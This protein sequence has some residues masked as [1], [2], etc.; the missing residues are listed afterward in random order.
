MIGALFDSATAERYDL[1]NKVCA[2]AELDK[3]VQALTEVMLA[4]NPIALRRTKFAL[5]K[6][7][8]MTVHQA[9]ALE[10]PIQP[11]PSREEGITDFQTKEGRTKRR[12][13]SKDFWQN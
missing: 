7:A 4:K 13:L 11:F 5:N 6:S 12:A 8:D 9:L 2:P 1:V 3:E 10:R